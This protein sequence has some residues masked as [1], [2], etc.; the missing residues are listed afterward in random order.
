MVSF[1][2]LAPLTRPY[3][4]RL[5]A[6]TARGRQ[7]KAM[8][9]PPFPNRADGKTAPNPIGRSPP[10]SAH[11]LKV[12]TPLQPL[13]DAILIEPD[14]LSLDITGLRDAILQDAI[15]III[16]ING[17]AEAFVVIIRLFHE[18]SH[19]DILRRRRRGNEKDAGER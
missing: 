15:P 7:G 14:Q 3:P 8:K 16:I 1:L 11:R 19:T 13:K 10:V 17:R 4:C 12:E 18:G 6:P 5:F 9:D 2:F